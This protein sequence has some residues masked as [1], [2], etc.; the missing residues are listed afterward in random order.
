MTIPPVIRSVYELLAQ[1]WGANLD[2]EENPVTAS[3]GV[4]DVVILK[5]NPRRLALIIINLSANTV[6]VRP[7]SNAASATAG[8]VLISGGGSLTMDPISDFNLASL[9]WHAIASGAA[10]SIYVLGL[11]VA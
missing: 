2:F 10:S 4:T 3:V 11:I 1:Q 8:I 6:Y 9:E 7:G 5:N